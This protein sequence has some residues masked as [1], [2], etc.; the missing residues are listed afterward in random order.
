MAELQSGKPL[1]SHRKSHISMISAKN[2]VSPDLKNPRY[3]ING[4]DVVSA[5]RLTSH[6]S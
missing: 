5:G 2:D 6:K 3:S 1:E 4:K